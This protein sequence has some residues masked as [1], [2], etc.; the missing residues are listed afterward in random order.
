MRAGGAESTTTGTGTVGAR[1]APPPH[2][3]TMSVS[4]IVVRHARRAGHSSD[5]SE[6][7][8]C[9]G[10]KVAG[11]VDTDPSAPPNKSRVVLALWHRRGVK[12]TSRSEKKHGGA[13]AG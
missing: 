9:M 12:L 11:S 3:P 6:R 13:A 8:G 7:A 1:W 2:P 4:A 10:R 5:W